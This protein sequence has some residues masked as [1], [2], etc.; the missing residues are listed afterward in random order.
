[1]V[2]CCVVRTCLLV[3]QLVVIIMVTTQAI[4]LV[5][6]VR[7]CL[8]TPEWV[9][10]RWVNPDSQDNQVLDTS[11]QLFRTCNQVVISRGLV[12]PVAQHNVRD[13]LKVVN[14][15]V[16][17]CQLKAIKVQCEDLVLVWLVLRNLDLHN[18]RVQCKVLV[19]LVI[20][21]DNHV[22][23]LAFVLEF[24]LEQQ[25]Y[26]HTKAQNQTSNLA[27]FDHTQLHSNRLNQLSP[28]L[29]KSR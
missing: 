6:L 26:P 7:Q 10:V 9:L 17:V 21:A 28:F 22:L 12:H 29:D 27:M 19:L 24:D 1:M 18:N 2:V 11:Y 5:W 16:P 15:N 13:G 3:L 23:V 14:N 25:T 20:Q 8:E 4:I